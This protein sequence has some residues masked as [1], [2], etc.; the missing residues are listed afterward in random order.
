MKYKSTRG[1]VKGISFKETVM[2]GLA[3]DGGLMIPEYIP[4]LSKD[5]MIELKDLNYKD[6]ALKIMKLFIDDIDISTIKNI[7]DKSYST[8]DKGDII[9]VKRF[10]N[11]IFIAEIF[12]GPTYAFKDIALQFLGNLFEHILLEKN[13]KM[14]ILGATSGDTG[15]AA[16]H[17]FKGKKDINIFI[18]HP[19]GKVSPI[20]ELQMTTVTDKNVFNLAID[21]TFDDC[22]YIV[23]SIFND[24]NFKQ[25]YS[26]GAI[27][28]INWARVLAQVVYYFYTYFRVANNFE[29]VY[30]SV[31]TGNFG[32]IFAGY[33]AKKIGL[34]IKK[35]I[36]ATNENNI[37]TRFVQNGD[38]SLSNVV[39]T[40]SPSMDIQIA[41]NLERYFYFLFGE[42]SDEVIKKIK[43]FEQN[44]KINF[45]KSEV[46]QINIDFYS[47]STSNDETLKI[48]ADFYKKYD[49][50]L[51][52]H[53][54]C[55]VNAT[56]KL[57]DGETPFINL[58][59][60]HP[61]KFQDAIYKA[62]SKLPE[63]P[64]RIMNLKNRDK[65][66]FKLKN[67]VD[68]VKEFIRKELNADTGN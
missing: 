10:D 37:L 38:Y 51:D 22:Q 52:P 39:E 68:E 24:L 31:P 60:A 58:A 14:N 40:Y 16:I 64:E 27:N 1:K 4:T 7:I 59:T 34:P 46:E 28:S 30:F 44:G 41:S 47:F 6:I 15:S 5:E 36:L 56:L 35:L 57:N 48:I 13:K 8:F 45:N 65:K 42:D 67:S 55:G 3:D 23:K 11:N 26:L 63:E 49:Y 9:P 32:N 43:E 62:I 21:G 33:I 25:N 29:K 12:H 2:M 50:I 54:A 61:A 19:H 66:Y 53:T 20:Q 17:G 18:L